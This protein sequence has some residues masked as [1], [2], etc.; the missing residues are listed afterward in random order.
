MTYANLLL[1]GATELVNIETQQHV[2]FSYTKLT[3]L[4]AYLAL[5]NKVHTREALANLFWPDL[6]EEDAKANLRRALF[7]LHQA[8]SAAGLPETLVCADRH[9]IYISKECLS[10]DAHA[11]EKKI[12]L[13]SITLLDQQIAL[14]Q[15]EFMDGIFPVEEDLANWVQNHRTQYAQKYI[16]FI[17]RIVALTATA[18]DNDAL[19]LRCRQL[20]AVDNVNE[21]AHA[22]LIRMYINSGNLATARKVY[23]AYR[24]SLHV[25]LGVEPSRQLTA[26]VE[27]F[28]VIQAP[29]E[30]SNN[31]TSPA[32]VNEKHVPGLTDELIADAQI[33]ATAMQKLIE[34]IEL[35][36]IATG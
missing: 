21:V 27:R 6:T 35:L 24:Q 15:G 8:L 23:A 17:E 29:T 13:D 22:T 12:T 10:I 26:L 16:F 9:T 5:E 32:S 20:I 3:L 18:K 7:N 4:L 30:H 28:T 36:K 11:F 31:L 25:E 33:I 19:E 14:Y 2:R 34:R 1:L